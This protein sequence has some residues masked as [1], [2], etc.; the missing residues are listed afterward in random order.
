M[1]DRPKTGPELKAGPKLRFHRCGVFQT[2]Y[3][4]FIR[5][6]RKSVLCWLFV[7]LACADS[8]GCNVLSFGAVGDGKTVDTISIR[9]AI[10]ACIGSELVFPAP[11]IYLSAPL[12]LSS[13]S[14]YI[15]EAGASLKAISGPF[16]WP[17]ASGLP[18]YAPSYWRYQPFIWAVDQ[19][20]ITLSGG[21]VID[22]SGGDFWWPAWFNGS[23]ID[24]LVMH[25]PYLLELYNCSDVNVT[26]VSLRDSPFWTVHPYISTRVELRSLTISAP[27]G[28]PNTDGIDPDSS[29]YIVIT[30]TTITNG[31]DCIAI[32]SGRGPTGAAFARPSHHITVSNITLLSGLGITIGAEAAGGVYDVLVSGVTASSVLAPVH[33]QNPRWHD[34]SW[35]EGGTISNVTFENYSISNAHTAIFINL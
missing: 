20:N 23:L 16:D 9:A 32:K 22:G 33:L 15:I 13:D 11:G 25:R 14:A 7:I 10:A 6:M 4:S 34:P 31:D 28:S 12:N 19:H 27:V 5:K 35:A 18:S 26:D 8:L 2:Y 17:I 1:Q 30:D 21:G 24:P 29:S 3:D